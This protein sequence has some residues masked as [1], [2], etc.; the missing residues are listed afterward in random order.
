MSALPLTMRLSAALIGARAGIGDVLA[1][2]GITGATRS[3]V[4]FAAFSTLTAGAWVVAGCD[5]VSQSSKRKAAFM[6]V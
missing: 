4:I 5:G 1:A 2:P 6:M 3:T